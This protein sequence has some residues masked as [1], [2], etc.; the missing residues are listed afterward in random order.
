MKQVRVYATRLSASCAKLLADL[1]HGRGAFARVAQVAR[2]RLLL[3]ECAVLAMTCGG[4]YLLRYEAAT[5]RY[6]QALRRTSDEL[7]AIVLELEADRRELQA[8]RQRRDLLAGLILSKNAKAQLLSDLTD[9][10]GHP[11]L[12]IVSI[13]PQPK[14]NGEQYARCRSLISMEGCFDDFLRFL[15]RLESTGAPCA[16]VEINV[17]SVS[18]GRQNAGRTAREESGKGGTASA[19]SA[20]QAA[21]AGAGREWRERISL[22]IETYAEADPVPEGPA[23]RR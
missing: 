16:V 8:V 17:Q 5:A 7:Q 3:V 14:E 13:S 18:V 11:G 22:V 15:R 20:Q 6:R 1:W 19:P 9:P 2:W 10:E 4:F 21:Q 23:P 12:E